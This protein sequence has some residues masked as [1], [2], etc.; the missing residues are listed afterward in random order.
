MKKKIILFLSF[1]LTAMFLT[2]CGKQTLT[3]EEKLIKQ[4]EQIALEIAKSNEYDV[5]EGYTVYYPEAP[6]TDKIIVAEGS[7]TITEITFDISE[8]QAEILNI[9]ISSELVT[10][11]ETLGTLLLGIVIGIILICL[12]AT[13]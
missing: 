12:L 2:G 4:M 8:G 9:E 13:C 7:A 6:K 11:G 10:V 1:L 5:P 3:A